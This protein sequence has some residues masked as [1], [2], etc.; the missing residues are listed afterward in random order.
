ACFEVWGS[1]QSAHRL[2]RRDAPPRIVRRP[3]AFT[4]YMVQGVF[5][6]GEHAVWGCSAFSGRITAGGAAS[7]PSTPHR[8]QFKRANS[9]HHWIAKRFE[10]L[11]PR[12]VV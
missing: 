3:D 12:V 6:N 4:P 2:E 10:L 9:Y 1:A 5:Q 7:H 8:A 11:T